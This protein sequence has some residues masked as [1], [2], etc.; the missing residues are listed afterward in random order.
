MNRQAIA[1]SQDGGTDSPLHAKTGFTLV[2]LISV[3]VVMVLVLTIAIG[4]HLMWKRQNALDAV[5][6]QVFAHLSLARQYAITQAVPTTFTASNRAL[7]HNPAV[8]TL[9]LDTDFVAPTNA[10]D[11]GLFFVST[12]STNDAVDNAED[13]PPSAERTLLGDVSQLPRRI[14]WFDVAAAVPTTEHSHITFLPDGTCATDESAWPDGT[15]DL[16]FSQDISP[17]VRTNRLLRR[18]VRVNPLTGL[19]RAFTRDEEVQP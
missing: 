17:A 8:G 18:T 3:M 13:T 9:S 6:M 12:A 7:K 4:A 14:V 10:P 5:A 19:A 11:R 15:R 2:E 16:V 1:T